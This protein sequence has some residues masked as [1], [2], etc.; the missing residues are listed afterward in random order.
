LI[1]EKNKLEKLDERTR[2]WGMME[3]IKLVN[4]GELDC[5]LSDY[6]ATDGVI[7]LT[8]MHLSEIVDDI[9]KLVNECSYENKQL[10]LLNKKIEIAME[11]LYEESSKTKDQK[12][13]EYLN[14]VIKSI[15]E[16][17]KKELEGGE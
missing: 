17:G 6:L 3:N 7:I 14:S 8:A 11:A 16:I 13:R 2:G 12:G 5:R 10:E 1:L 15:N 4:Y 9:L